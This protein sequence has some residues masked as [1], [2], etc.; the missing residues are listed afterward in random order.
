MTTLDMLN[1][2]SQAY[3]DWAAHNATKIDWNDPSVPMWKKMGF[4]SEQGYQYATPSAA[5]A[6]APKP[7]P[8]GLTSPTSA[9]PKQDFDE[10][11]AANPTSRDAWS[12]LESLLSE[13]GLNDL[14][15]FA[16]EQIIEGRSG[17]EVVQRMK[18]TQ[19]YKTRFKAIE[20]LKAK[21]LPAV[22]EAEVIEAEK[23]YASAFQRVGMPSG[24]YDSPEDF[25]KYIV[26]GISPKELYEDRLLAGVVAVRNNPTVQSQMNRLYGAGLSE[27]DL[28]AYF[29]DESKALPLLQRRQAA[30]SIA[31]QSNTTGFGDINVNQAERLAGQGI[32]AAQAQQGFGN[33][34][35]QK[36]LLTP[37]ASEQGN[38]SVDTAIGAAFNDNAADKKKLDTRRQERI[39][40]F[41]GGGSYSKSNSGST[42]AGS[43]S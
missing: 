33:L 31:A 13:Y 15:D 40:K 23:G 19:S 29:L 17:N 24:F 27:G 5:P 14:N 4:D 3:K 7:V 30:A 41:S 43:A 20:E 22:S 39:A 34:A 28:V 6:P 42:G 9:S 12:Y 2:D 11:I 35:Q 18:T 38:I 26:N 37:L 1:Q 16:K 8:D 10:Y 25:A 32:T 21:G 36:A